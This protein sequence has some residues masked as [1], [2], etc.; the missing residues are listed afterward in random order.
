MSH[1][2]TTISFAS[3]GIQSIPT[4]FVAAGYKIFLGKK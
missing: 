2:I 1:R 4:D 3:T